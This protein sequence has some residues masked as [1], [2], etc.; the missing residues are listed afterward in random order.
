MSFWDWT[1][2]RLLACNFWLERASGLVEE[3]GQSGRNLAG[4]SVQVYNL[5][6]K[7]HSSTNQ[8]DV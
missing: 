6:G 3:F 5:A 8:A 1:I 2:S 7:E 4:S